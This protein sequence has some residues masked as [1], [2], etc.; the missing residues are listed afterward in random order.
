MVAACENGLCDKGHDIKV[1]LLGGEL[2][3]NYTDERVLLTGGANIVY[4]GSFE[5]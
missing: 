2:T 5:Y 4:E 3:V 1:S